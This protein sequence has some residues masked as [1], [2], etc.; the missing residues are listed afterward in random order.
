MLEMLKRSA[1]RCAPIG[2]IW[3]AAMIA[4]AAT[5][6][7]AQSQAYNWRNVVTGGG[8]GYVVNIIFNPSQQ[9]LVYVRTDIGGAYRWNPATSTWTPLMDFTSAANWNDLGVESIA[10]DPVNPNNLYIAVGLYTNNFTSS[11]GAI[12]VSHDQGQ[13]F[14]R[15]A[16]PFK[17]G[18]NMPGRGMGERLAIDPNLNS[19]I[20]FGAR[21]GN[22]LWRSTNSGMTW[23]KVTS[24]IGQATYVQ[25]AGDNYLGDTDGPVW[26][27]FDPTSGTPG[28]GSKSIYVGLANLTNSVYH[29]ADGGNTWTPLAGTPSGFMPHHGVLASN[30]M[31]YMTFNNNAGPY[32]GTLGDVWKYNTQTGAWTLISPV[33]ST[34]SSDYFGYG[35]LAVDPQNPNTLVVAAVNSWWPDTILWR[36]TNGGQTWS[37]IWNWTSYPDRS[38]LY[39]QDIS[40]A[41]WLNFGVTNSVA[42]VP[43]PKLGWMVDGIAIDPFNPNHMLYGTGATLYG[44]TDLTNWDAG[45][46]INITVAAAGIEETAVLGLVSPP[47]GAPLFSVMGDVTGFEHTDITKPPAAMFTSPNNGTCSSIDYAE[48]NPSFL[49]RVGTP[50]YSSS[51]EVFSTGFTFSGGSSWFQGNVD[52]GGVAGGGIIAAAADA[53]RVLW[54]DSGAGVNFSTTN[55]NSWTL[56]TGIPTGAFIASD[57]VNPLQFY[58]FSGGTFY[59]STNGA[60]SFTASAAAGLPSTAKIKAVPGHQG[61]VWLA[62]GTGGLWH[63]T[64]SGVS[65]VQLAGGTEA[66]V[67]GLGMPAPAQTYP[68]LFI[69]GAVS[70]VPGIFRSDN[71][72]ASW[73][74]IND[75]QH[76]Y[77]ITSQCMTGDPRV[78]GRVYFC[79][80]GRGIIVGDIAT[81][82]TPNFSLSATPATVT[83]GGTATSA[84]TV[85]PTGGFTGTVTFT[86][87]GLPSGV[88]ASFSGDV[89]TFT[90]SATAATGPA[91]V[92]ITG[93]SGTL[94]HTT[95][96]TLTVN[97]AAPPNFSLSATPAAVTQGGTATS[98]ITVTPS[99][100]FTGTVTF[101]ASGLPSGVTAGFSGDVVTFRASATAATGPATVTIT[102]T[103]GTLTHTATLTLT[104]SAASGGTGGVTVTT[105]INSNSPW[106]DDEGVKISNTASITALSITITI[107]NTG[108]LAFNGQYNTVGSS[109]SQAHSSTSSAIAYQYSLVAGQTL[110]PGSGYLFDAQASGTGTAHSVTGDT[111]TITYTTG[112]HAFTQ[113]GVL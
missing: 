14:T 33:P 66:D 23:S 31:L 65:F 45:T 10:T 113:S 29:S 50:T 59:V 73:V 36:S 1:R 4:G 40:A 107:Q 25:Q 28:Q 51:P 105:V 71:M 81:S 94:T 99:G 111:Y 34:S 21:S 55:G 17:N 74:Q 88:T 86:A 2:T 87:S 24:F 41:P 70:G 30:G 96:L 5:P 95:T 22:G 109:I 110:N 92:T 54:S 108:G 93:T 69:S 89:V 11:N 38:L 106:F 97:T 42:P 49:V 56:S 9:G 35:G 72:G 15:V 20:Y 83:Q 7:A 75:S 76:Q 62:G 82:G 100:G 77:G 79:T 16:L 67:I 60:L 57:R 103:S 47:N 98:T 63:S 104:V 48:L 78:Y 39:T 43:S 80:N 102:G 19:A 85:T 32:D 91:T 26:V 84:I 61:D 3:L 12:L 27:V 52:P 53:S 18:G 44:T 6:A 90:A 68:A 37:Q 64:N 58:G 46:P 101:T 13:T 8:G 112:G